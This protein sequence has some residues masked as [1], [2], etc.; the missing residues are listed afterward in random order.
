MKECTFKPSVSKKS[1]KLI[2]KYN[3]PKELTA[4]KEKRQAEKAKK[5]L[6]EKNTKEMG[7]CTFTPQI[8]KKTQFGPKV[9]QIT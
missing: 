1:Q 5:L 6:I 9:T 7:E 4:Q 2:Q 3:D 8:K